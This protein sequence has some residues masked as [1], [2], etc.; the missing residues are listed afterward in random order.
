MMDIKQF[1]RYL[2]EN[3]VVF[4]LEEH[5]NG[6]AGAKDAALYFDP[7]ECAAVYVIDTERG[8]AAM[9]MG[10]KREDMDIATLDKLLGYKVMGR[11]DPRIVK[12]ATGY[13]AGFLPIVGHKLPI[14]FDKG[15]TVCDYIYGCTGDKSHIV[16]IKPEDVI[17]LSNML[18]FVE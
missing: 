11:A 9:I 12:Q 4:E 8:L 7:E 10:S 18:M 2:Q 6:I 3:K 1:E 14:L 15:L 13:E 5:E 17:R 16:K